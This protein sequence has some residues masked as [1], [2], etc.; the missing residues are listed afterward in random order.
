M[1]VDLRI[2]T[3]KPNKMAD[4][5]AVYKEFAWPLQQKYVDRHS[6]GGTAQ[7]EVVEDEAQIVRQVF[8]RYHVATATN[9]VFAGACLPFTIPIVDFSGEGGDV[10]AACYCHAAQEAI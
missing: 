5:V 8:I 3:C 4:F 1:I 9:L 2:Y 6:G 7:F 10:G